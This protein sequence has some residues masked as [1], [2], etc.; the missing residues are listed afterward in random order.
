MDAQLSWLFMHI[1]GGSEVNVVVPSRAPL[2]LGAVS[3]LMVCACK[4]MRPGRVDFFFM[5]NTPW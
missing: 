5:I 4:T 3:S 1:S 2:I